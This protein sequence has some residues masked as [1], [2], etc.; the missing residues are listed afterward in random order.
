MTP[1]NLI[2]GLIGLWLL[3]FLLSR[4][5]FRSRPSAPLPPGP[6]GK[7]II[8]NLADLPPPE[9]QEW[10]HWL[11]FKE[12]YG[13]ISSLTILGQ[14]IVILNDVR[15]AFD[16]L[17][18]R[19]NIYS[20]RPRLTFAGEIVGWNDALGMQTYSHQFRA[21]RKVMH[22]VLGSKHTTARF[23]SL[24]EMEVRRFLKRMLDRPEDLIQHIR[25][26]AGAVILKI[27]YG[28]TIE[29]H[30]RDP[31][32]DLVNE[33][34]DQFSIAGSPGRW[35]V[36]TIPLCLFF[37][38]TQ[39]C[40]ISLLTF[41]TTYA[42][43][44]LPAWFPG[45]SFKRTGLAWNRTLLTTIEKPYQFVRQQMQRG[46]YTPSYVSSLLKGRDLN[47]LTPEE[48][49]IIK[50]TAGSLYTAGADT[51]VSVLSI[52]FLAMAL[53]PEIQDKAYEELERVVGRARLPTFADREHLP[54]IEAIVKE[55][56]RW[57]PIAPTGIP[58]ECT[59][60]DIYEGYLIPKGSI[61]IPHIWQMAQDPASYPN[62]TVFNPMRFLSPETSQMDPH[63]LAFGFG[64]RI[65]PGRLLADN[66]IFLT[67]AQSLAVF[68]FLP[69]DD[70]EGLRAEFAPG[71][72]SHP[73]PYALKVEVRGEEQRKV[74]REGL[75][76]VGWGV[77]DAGALTGV[78]C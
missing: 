22:R 34:M 6:K 77:S 73:L 61:I 1:T 46:K 31:L 28:Y 30:G 13:P 27:A 64:R 68:R 42:V 9:M 38:Q 36:D 21:Y 54:Y 17:E 37:C 2:L 41:E 7:P 15:M 23:N 69:R 16:L 59:Q 33:A 39:P 66:T 40:D 26:E 60:D 57:H 74:V 8:G 18:K 11:Q 52:F 12:R 48:E 4:L 44:H 20:S 51:T 19:S 25:T 49:H 72:V 63:H 5:F 65:C 32:V 14:T 43:K 45:A 75:E 78:I 24:Q 56:L 35:L 29:P 3:Y 71:V 10:R 53:H 62:P 55:S 58:H 76:E 50:W 70:A 67:I 47:T